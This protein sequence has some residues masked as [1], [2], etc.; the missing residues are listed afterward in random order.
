M[1]I[2]PFPIGL[3][4]SKISLGDATSFFNQPPGLALLRLKDFT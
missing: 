2:L 1:S 4:G 3:L